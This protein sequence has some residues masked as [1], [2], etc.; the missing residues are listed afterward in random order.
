MGSV[1]A[2]S[3]RL[4]GEGAWATSECVGCGIRAPVPGG[5]TPRRAR[6]GFFAEPA[7]RGPTSTPHREHA[8]SPS[9]R[10]EA[11][12]TNPI[13]T[14]C[15][16]CGEAWPA[17]FCPCR[18]ESR[19]DPRSTSPPERAGFIRRRR[20]KKILPR[21]ARMP[22]HRDVLVRAVRVHG[23]ARDRLG[24]RA[25]V[26]VRPEKHAKDHSERR[27]AVRPGWLRKSRSKWRYEF[28]ASFGPRGRRTKPPRVG[29][30]HPGLSTRS[31]PRGRT[32][33]TRP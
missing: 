23:G 17:G 3:R 28:G 12:P 2:A 15:A 9:N 22:G 13:E 30:H 27:R 7:C 4:Y 11:A 21:A 5:G 24:A 33:T 14:V 16:F 29:R 20:N 32:P 26:L 18:P 10:L 1:G 31:G 6:S 19:L 8:P 25:S